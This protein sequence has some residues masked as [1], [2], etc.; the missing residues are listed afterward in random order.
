MKTLLVCLVCLLALL[1]NH[2]RSADV[3]N[4]GFYLPGIRDANLTDVKVTLTL[5][6]E[7]VG[8]IYDIDALA[9]TYEDMA[10][11]RR[12][13][14]SGKVNMVIVPGMELAETF[15]ADE[16]TEGFQGKHRGTGEGL[17]LIVRADGDIRQFSHLRGR[18]VL[19]LANDRLS[20]VFLESRCRALAGLACADFL[21][22]SDE[23]HSSL[24]IHKV[25]F[26]QADAALV[27]ISA[28]H[29]AGELNPQV[30]QRLR[31]LLDWKTTALSFG[32][33][34]AR[35]PPYLRERVIDSAMRVISTVRGKQILE[36]FKTDTME[37]AGVHELQPYWSLHRASRDSAPGKLKRSR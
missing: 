7:E 11:L 3:L 37:R 12:D 33:M 9:S 32:L 18:S 30:R 29:A 24:A 25:F 36:L 22:V 21:R 16:L 6:A 28:L 2:A 23:K 13:M 31:S 15:D 14:L 26:G 8:K 27:S 5:W 17:V 19:R 1:S 35:T 4:M 10:S 34:S 20:S